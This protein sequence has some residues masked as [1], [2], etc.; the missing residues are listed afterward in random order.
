MFLFDVICISGK[1]GLQIK[2]NNDKSNDVDE[3][4]DDVDGLEEIKPPSDTQPQYLNDVVV[5]NDSYILT[6]LRLT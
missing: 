4:D 3:D 2:T 6:T 5:L 1:V